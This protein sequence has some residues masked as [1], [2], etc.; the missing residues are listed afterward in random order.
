[1]PTSTE[2]TEPPSAASDA[3]AC[4]EAGTLSAREALRA[5]VAE[6]Y[7]AADAA[8]KAAEQRK[9]LIR[10]QL[11][12]L[13]QAIG[14]PVT[15]AGLEF[16]WREGT[17]GASYPAQRVEWAVRTLHDLITQLLGCA[18]LPQPCMPNL[19]PPSVPE[20]DALLL[21][22]EAVRS[23]DAADTADGC[24]PG[25]VDDRLH[26]SV[27]SVQSVDDDHHIAPG[28]ATT[29]LVPHSLIEELIATVEHLAAGREE[30]VRAGAL[31]VISA[32]AKQRQ[33][34]RHGR[35]QGAEDGA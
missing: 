5:L 30:R 31:Y 32:E 28:S 21:K 29:Y 35:G 2:R 12:Q 25:P 24:T 34:R 26:L 9:K 6:E 14:E 23:T 19:A 3:F 22:C 4:W 15:C 13:V 11:E 1:M 27:V 7:L 17:L 33:E 18:Q 10:S 8:F 16:A 20:N